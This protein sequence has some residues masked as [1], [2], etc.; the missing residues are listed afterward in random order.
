MTSRA[1]RIC[2]V[3][4]DR[5]A[6]DHNCINFAAFSHRSERGAVGGDIGVGNLVA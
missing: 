3:F 1:I 6:Y 2:P 5:T 4:G